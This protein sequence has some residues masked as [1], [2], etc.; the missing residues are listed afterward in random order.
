MEIISGKADFELEGR[1]AVTLGKFDGIHRG[2]R[3]LID[4]VL[5]RRASGL[6]SAVFTFDISPLSFFTGCDAGE[7]TSREDKRRIFDHLGIDVLIEYPLTAESAAMAP[8]DFITD[9]L[10]KRMHMAYIAVGSDISFGKDAMGRAHL[11]ERMSPELDYEAEIVDKL[12]IDGI[13]VSSSRIRETVARGDMEYA[14]K[15]IGV[16]YAI[17]GRISHGRELGRTI[18]FPTVNLVPE[19][20][21]LMPPYGVYYSEISVLNG[22]FRG[23]TNVGIRPTV[24][25]DHKV[26][27]ET[28]IIDFDRDVYDMPMT[29]KLLHFA[30]SEI[31]FDGIDELK[32]QITLDLKDGINWHR[33]N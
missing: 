23:I 28:H 20:N 13:E 16:P 24:S 26:S 32:N 30:R 31:R 15:L 5:S 27:V 12:L 21:K 7:L 6:K 10:V 22:H 2:H 14:A 1:Y 4:R 8:E 18:G 3:K 17:S 25:H 33:N 19:R 9:V 29:V 11:L